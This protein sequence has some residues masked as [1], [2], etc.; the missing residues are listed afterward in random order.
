MSE[1]TK[2]LPEHSRLLAE[3]LGD[4]KQEE[5]AKLLGFAQQ[6]L[7]RLLAGRDAGLEVRIKCKRVAGVPLGAWPTKDPLGVTDEELDEP[8]GGEAA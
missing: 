7:S 1:E 3:W 5:G 2:P 8:T 4:R 6:T